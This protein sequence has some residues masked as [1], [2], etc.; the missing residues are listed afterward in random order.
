LDFLNSYASKI[1]SELKQLNLPDTPKTLYHPQRYILAA[2]GKRI[3]PILALMGCGIC[4]KSPDK[5]IPAALA[6]EL[7]HNFTLLHDDIMDQ[8]ESRRGQS[9]VHIKWDTATAILAGDSMFVQAMLQLQQV[10]DS[11]DVKA[12]YNVLLD[13]TNKVCEG[14][15]LDMEFEKRTDVTS[16]EYLEMISGK[17]SALISASLKLGGVSAGASADQLNQLEIIGNS[18]GLAFQI[19]DDLLDVVADP[20]KFG[21]RKGGDIFEGKKTYLMV[22]TLECC[23]ATERQWLTGRLKNRPLDEKDVNKVIEL[24]STYK[25]TESSEQLIDKYYQQAENALNQFDD[26]IYKGDLIQLINYLKKRDF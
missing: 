23:N 21:K 12:A 11:V 16:D 15:A 26:S 25:I 20:E 3:R 9:S 6:V 1:E 14:Q 7:I 2:S 8:A 19:Q 10:S 24:Y 18:L 17:T 22:K 4:G 5:A 13:G